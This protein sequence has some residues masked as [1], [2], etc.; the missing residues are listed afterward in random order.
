M[1]ENIYFVC[2]F[3]FSPPFVF[4]LLLRSFYASDCYCAAL[5]QIGAPPSSLCRQSYF[6]IFRIKKKT[7]FAHK[8]SFDWSC[9]FLVLSIEFAIKN[10]MESWGQVLKHRFSNFL[11]FLH[12][13]LKTKKNV[14]K[15]NRLLSAP[16]CFTPS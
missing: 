2:V 6:W 11:H 8:P 15:V 1:S 4:L 5:L 16:L 10:Y 13:K 14:K 9:N 3:S 12:K 7:K